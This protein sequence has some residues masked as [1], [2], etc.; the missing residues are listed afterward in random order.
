M[1]YERSSRRSKPLYDERSDD[2]APLERRPPAEGRG[3][4][5]CM[6][7][8]AFDAEHDDL[9]EYCGSGGE[10]LCC[11]NCTN[12]YHLKCLEPPLSKL[13]AG[14]WNCPD[15]QFTCEREGCRKDGAETQCCR[16][17]RRFI[18]RL[19]AIPRECP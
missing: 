19:M 15:C 6:A 3:A 11:D 17:G 14:I 18:S 16:C 7:D 12:V 1:S 13:P 10:L 8:Q 2:E 9:C 5:Q 4:G